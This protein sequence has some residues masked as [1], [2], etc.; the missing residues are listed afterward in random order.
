MHRRPGRSD[1]AS[2]S[3]ALPVPAAP[4][5]KK[6]VLG[7]D[8]TLNPVLGQPDAIGLLDLAAHMALPDLAMDPLAR[9]V[10]VH[11]FSAREPYEAI[12][13]IVHELVPIVFHFRRCLSSLSRIAACRNTSRLF[14]KISR[15]VATSRKVIQNSKASCGMPFG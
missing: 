10:S 9:A 2:S 5:Q 1:S 14:P 12:A 4:A 3:D 15:R 7:C 11:L 8:P 13:R 6:R